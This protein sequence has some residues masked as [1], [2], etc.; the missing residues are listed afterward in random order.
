[1]AKIVPAELIS[2]IQGKITGDGEGYFYVSKRNGKVYF[3]KR[4]EGYQKHQSPRQKWNSAAF[5][6]AHKQLHAIEA[7]AA[8]TAQMSADYEAA[9][10]KA[11]NGKSYPTAHA[12]KFNSLLCAWKQ[13]HPF[14]E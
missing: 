9:G 8:L 11:S 14:E 7:D 3:R 4:E 6:Y 12:W 5:A 2:L 10:H 1:M 13:E